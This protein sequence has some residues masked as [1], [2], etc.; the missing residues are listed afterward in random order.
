MLSSRRMPSWNATFNKEA[1]RRASWSRL[2]S[3]TTFG[4][5]HRRQDEPMMKMVD[6]HLF[7]KILDNTWYYSN[8]ICVFAETIF[9]HLNLEASVFISLGWSWWRE[10][11][12]DS[13][14]AFHVV[15]IIGNDT[16]VAG[17]GR[18]N[19]EL[20]FCMAEASHSKNLF[21]ICGKLNY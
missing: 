2:R 6:D 13:K 7:V 9:S 20:D 15:D 16:I 14:D 8:S 18:W 10:S 3:K 17:N 4:W 12:G 21:N 1:L 5:M 11:R 19:L